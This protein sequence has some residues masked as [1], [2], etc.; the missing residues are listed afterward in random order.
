[1]R[2]ALPVALLLLSACHHEPDFDERYSAAQK[3]L[4]DTAR[5][6]DAQLASGVPSESPTANASPDAP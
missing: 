4:D 5:Q 2:R 6:I 3:Q 1:M